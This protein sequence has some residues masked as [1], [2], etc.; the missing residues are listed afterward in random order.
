MKLNLDGAVAVITGA[1][2]G[3]GAELAVRMAARGCR[4]ALVD[5]DAAGLDSVSR[6]I[7]ALRRAPVTTHVADLADYQTI[8]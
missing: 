2:S 3:M 4:L 7:A 5:R 6:R 8:R 1:A